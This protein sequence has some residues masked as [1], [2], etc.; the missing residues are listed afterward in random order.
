MDYSV[1]TVTV[2]N[3][4]HFDNTTGQT[5]TIKK[6]H[7]HPKFK[8]HN[9]KMRHDVAILRINGKITYNENAQPLKLPS[10]D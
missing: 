2:G 5:F 8:G 7:T 9:N 10:P 3:T 6:V 1:L 4:I